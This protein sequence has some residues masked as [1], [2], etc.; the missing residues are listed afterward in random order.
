MDE[1]GFLREIFDSKIVD[2]LKFFFGNPT[3]DFY[4]KEISDSV[5]VPMATTHRILQRLHNLEVIEENNIS[6][7]KIYRL[8]D[9][10]KVKYLGKFIKHSVKAVEIFVQGVR[11]VPNVE[12]II[13]NGKELDNRATL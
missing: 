2:V 3:K 1:I 13:L 5:S 4:L 8:A 7:F 6:K 11:K 12:Q 10:E 9:N